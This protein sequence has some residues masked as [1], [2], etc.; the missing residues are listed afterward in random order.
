MP[1]NSERPDRKTRA[2][3]LGRK[4]SSYAKLRTRFSVSGLRRIV[5]DTLSLR[6][7][8]TAA[9]LRPKRRAISLMVTLVGLLFTGSTSG[10]NLP[11]TESVVNL[12]IFD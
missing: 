8:E 1:I 7:L 3:R 9:G 6:A 5:C 11:G 4:P 12:I 10:Q 2:A